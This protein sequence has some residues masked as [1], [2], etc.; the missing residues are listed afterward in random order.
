MT[1]R[2]AAEIGLKPLA[3]IRAFTYSGTDP[4]TAWKS[5]TLAV[6]AALK[7]TGLAM[8][9][10]DLIEIHEAFAAQV[11]ANFRELG[12]AAEDEE[13]INVNGSCIALGHPLGATGARILTTLSHEMQRRDAKNGLIAICGGGGMGV[14]M[15]IEKA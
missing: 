4:R 12:L 2:K 13:R 7:K 3:A 6:K 11:L 9:D 8:K 15:V 1:E 14:C 5:V 10:I